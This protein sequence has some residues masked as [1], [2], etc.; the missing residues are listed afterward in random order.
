LKLQVSGLGTHLSHHISSHALQLAKEN[1]GFW[2]R[3]QAEQQLDFER[4]L[5]ID[6]SLSVLRRARAEGLAH[7]V[8]ILQPDTTQAPRAPSEFPG[9]LHFGELMR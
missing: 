1:A 6:D 9:I 4:C 3:L 5:F 2:L 7:T 8:Q